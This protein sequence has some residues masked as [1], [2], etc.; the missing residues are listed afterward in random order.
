VRDQISSLAGTIGIH[1]RIVHLGQLLGRGLDLIVVE[2]V[3][4]T[5]DQLG[6]LFGRYRERFL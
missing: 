3:D 6:A 2:A 4:Q 1:E 5:F